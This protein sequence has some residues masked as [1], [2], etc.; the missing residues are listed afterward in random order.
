MPRFS[1]PYQPEPIE[2][3]DREGDPL[4]LTVRKRRLRVSKIVN[5]WRVDEEWWRKEI[6]RIYFLIELENNK[7]I[8]VFHDLLRGGWFKQNWV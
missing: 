8:T 7:R 1:G 4:A 3:I 5:T 2:V 6:S